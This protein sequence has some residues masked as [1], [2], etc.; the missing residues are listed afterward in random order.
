MHTHAYLVPWPQEPKSPVTLC[1]KRPQTVHIVFVN[2]SCGV[3]VYKYLSDSEIPARQDSFHHGWLCSPERER[4][5]YHLSPHFMPC[6][7][8]SSAME[9][10]WDVAVIDTPSLLHRRPIGG[11]SRHIFNHHIQK[12][13]QVWYS[14]KNVTFPL[15]SFQDKVSRLQP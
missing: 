15:Q 12:Q 13:F 14:H 1:K 10:T 5:A 9:Q 8:Q 4:E 3:G 11:S 7:R 6:S 2:A